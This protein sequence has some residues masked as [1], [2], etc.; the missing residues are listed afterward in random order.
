MSRVARDGTAQ[1]VSRD[2]FLRR[3]GGQGNVHVRFPCSA[4]HSRFGNLTRSILLLLHVMTIHTYPHNVCTDM[5]SEDCVCSFF[6]A[7]T[8]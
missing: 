3:E 5:H 2:Q 1:P 4:D 7:I 8:Q 6:L